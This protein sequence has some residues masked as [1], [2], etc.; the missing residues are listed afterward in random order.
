MKRRTF[1]QTS[2]LA[3]VPVFVNG[4]GLTAVS[5]SRLFSLINGDSDRV[6]VLIQ[7]N[8]GN[9]GLNMLVPIDQYDQLAAV[10]ANV[11]IPDRSLLKISDING[12][13]PAMT[14]MKELYEDGKINLIQSV[15]YPNQNRSHFRSTDIWMS[16][17]DADKYE[18][19]GWLG[20]YFNEDH[21]TF[22]DNYPNTEFSDPFALTIGRSVSETCQ[23]PVANFSLAVNDPFNLSPIDESVVGNLPNNCYGNEMRYVIDIIKKTNAYGNVIT[24]AA[25]HGTNLSAKYAD[26]NP[27]AQQL[28]T[29]AL[30]ISGGLKTKIYVANIGGF[31]THASQVTEDDPAQGTHALLLELLSEAICAFQDDLQLQGLDKRVMGMTFSEFGRRIRSNDSF[32]TDHGTAAPLI[33]FGS[34]VNPG[35]LGDNPEI[36]TEVE[37]QEG[38]P[39]QYDF[40]S[41]YGTMLM[42]WFD[43]S[44]SSIRNLLY[45]D[46]QHLPILDPCESPTSQTDFEDASMEAV[47]FPNPATDRITVQFVS[48]GRRVQLDVFDAR[49]HHLQTIVDKNMAGG[50]HQ[51]PVELSGYTTGV[52]FVR[53]QEDNR[54]KTLRVIKR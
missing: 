27:L 31:D 13:H 44:E 6:L 23:G 34:C 25:N 43:V 26:N 47:L 50:E 8:G 51:V 48:V 2:S 4:M 24:D 35:V 40:R 42:D 12:F 1:L 38:V 17:S 22:P 11:L 18:T 45:E 37:V 16:A 36:S 54:Q 9:D 52:Y 53:I 7:L 20:R 3:S 15:G 39:M 33:V 29:I 30:L 14:H 19:T 5:N 32:G 21:P 46:F 10:R 49:G 28:K 41:V